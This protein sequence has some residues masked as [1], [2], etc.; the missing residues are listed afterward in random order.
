M[1]KLPD[2]AEAAGA[3]A[4]T[5]ANERRT[6]FRISLSIESLSLDTRREKKLRETVGREQGTEI[7]LRFPP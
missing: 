5:A 4:R 1:V 7:L 6:R 3:R 2:W